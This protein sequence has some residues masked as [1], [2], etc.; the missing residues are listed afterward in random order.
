MNHPNMTTNV[1][2]RSTTS[3][4]FNWRMFLILLLGILSVVAARWSVRIATDA[5]PAAAVRSEP[6]EPASPVVVVV[7]L[8]AVREEA[9]R[10][11]EPR[12]AYA[13]KKTRELTDQFVQRIEEF[14]DGRKDGAKSFADAALG[15]QSKWELIK[16]RDGHRD[17]IAARFAEYIFS[18]EELSTMLKTAT[19]EYAQGLKAVENELL[20]KVRADLQ[21][22]PTIAL[23]AFFSEQQLQSRFAQIIEGVMAG[24]ATNLK[25]D[26]GREVGSLAIDVLVAAVITESLAAMATRLGISGAVL[27]TGAAASW[28]TFGAGIVIGITV[29]ALLGW[30]ISWFYDPAEEIAGNVAASLDE[31]KMSIIAGDPQAWKIRD[32]AAAMAQS[33]DNPAVRSKAAQV[34]ENITR[35]G[36]LGLKHVLGRVAEVQRLSRQLTL[37]QLVSQENP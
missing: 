7:D 8:P 16:S 9:W 33:H 17:F 31:V 21:D 23:P 18:Q 4:Q 19:Q 6:V 30:I 32:Q 12:L 28:A 36:A 14:F 29:D 15:W 11:I 24:V 27:G 13:D 37:K 1:Q 20:V 34:S 2:G 22:L 25:V 5:P 35:G 10:R 26:I 3:R